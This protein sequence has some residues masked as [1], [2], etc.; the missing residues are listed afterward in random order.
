M[1]I[2][3]ILSGASACPN[4]LTAKIEAKIKRKHLREYSSDNAFSRYFIA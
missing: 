1:T 3:P 4:T 2:Y